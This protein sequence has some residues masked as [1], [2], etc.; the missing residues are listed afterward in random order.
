LFV[1]ITNSSGF[2][3]NECIPGDP[4][5]NNPGNN[6]DFSNM[7]GGPFHTSPSVLPIELAWFN[8]SVKNRNVLLS[9]STIS[10]INSEKFE[11]ERSI[12]N[13]IWLYVGEVKASGNSNSFKHYSFTDENLNSGTYF[14]RLKMIDNDGSFKFSNEIKAEIIIPK[15]FSLSQNYPNPFNPATTI[16]F[17]LSEDGWT[18]LKVF[19]ILGREIQTLVNEELKAGTVHSVIFNGSE[20]PSGIYLYRLETNNQVSVKKLILMK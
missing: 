9:W 8:S 16:T 13:D 7:P 19:D 4:G 3:S 11:I 2:F 12:D 10:E 6:P 14:Y 20:L 15:V 5:A 17:T 1:I 18:T